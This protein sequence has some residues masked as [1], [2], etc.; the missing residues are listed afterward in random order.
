MKKLILLMSILFSLIIV[1]AQTDIIY[2][3]KSK[4]SIYNCKI[5]EVRDG[6]IV[7][8]NKDSVP[9]TV[10]AVAIS[11]DGNYITLG[12]GE[13]AIYHSQ[14]RLYNEHY[15]Y[16]EKKYKRAKINKIFGVVLTI[17]GFGAQV[18]GLANDTFTNMYIFY[19]GAI[20]FNVGLPLWISGGIKASNNK[21]AMNRTKNINLSLST[22]NNGVGLVLNF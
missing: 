17:A 9:D 1:N 2:P 12:T 4:I 3:A 21:K 5:T 11:K 14:N 19:G 18:Y 10:E 8:F 6:N 20:V 16:Y 7:H 22:T 15:N 13:M